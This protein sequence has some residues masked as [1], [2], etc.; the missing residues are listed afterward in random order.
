MKHREGKFKG[1]NDLNIYYQCWEPEVSPKA[2]L[3]VA[4]GL[5][6]HSGRYKNL[7]NYF[8]PKGYAVWA[9]DHRGHGKSEGMRSYVER[10]GEY[11]ADL[12][13]FFG[14]VRKE[15]K[16]DKIFLIGHSMGGTIATVYMIEH[17]KD[18]DGAILSGASLTQTAAVSPVLLALA[19]VISALMPKM[20]VTVLDASALS[21]DQAVVDAYVNDPLVFRGKVPARMG[22]ELVRMWKAL[23]EEMPKL[24]LPL[25]IMHGAD[26]KL[27]SPEGSKILYEKVSSKDK[28]LKLYDGLYHEIFNEPE[29]K[30][31]MADIESWLNKHL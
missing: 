14:I 27:S 13:T 2:V 9:I 12:K 19:G 3:L 18:F 30:K 6:E 10:F 16:T 21:K 25:L 23:P 29:H 26:D 4:H 28:T 17:Q 24:N 20:G 1:Y 22:A 8:V 31:V 5:A 15:H 11:L 7:V